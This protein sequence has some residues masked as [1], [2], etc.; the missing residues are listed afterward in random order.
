MEVMNMNVKDITTLIDH[1]EKSSLVELELKIGDSELALR[2]REAFSGDDDQ[3]RTSAKTVSGT[4]VQSYEPSGGQAYEKSASA[5]PPVNDDTINAPIVGT[6]YRAA[7]PDSPA[8]VEEGSTV[9]AGQTICILEAMKVM[10]ELEADF[11]CRIVSI[12]I[13]NGDMVEY[14]TPLFVVERI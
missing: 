6:F 12:L 1:L 14:G 11:D 8:F 13:E 7:S 9:K 4:P 5:V 2:K 3:P 10:N